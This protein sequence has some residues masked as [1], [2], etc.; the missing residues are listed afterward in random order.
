MS[1][2]NIDQI[3]EYLW[4]P[5]VTALVLLWQKYSGIDTRTKLL[6]QAKGFHELQR[7]EDRE[8]RNSQHT[9][10]M[11]KLDS[12]ETRIKNGG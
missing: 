2:P 1:T 6:E 10:I 12:L 3:V 9:V 5:I 4:I 11:T 8:L 7:I